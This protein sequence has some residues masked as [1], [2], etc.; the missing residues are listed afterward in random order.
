M[1]PLL[2]SYE[3]YS[4]AGVEPVAV[5]VADGGCG[6]V[7][8]KLSRSKGWLLERDAR[9]DEPGGERADT[10]DGGMLGGRDGWWA[11]VWAAAESGRGG[12]G[13]GW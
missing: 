5:A 13:G 2:G 1:G 8:C 12:G 6:L 3:L 4:G 9:F 7:G 10:G 11:G